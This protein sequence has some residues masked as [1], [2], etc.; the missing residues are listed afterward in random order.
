MNK[1]SLSF[2]SLILL[3]TFARAE[4]YTEWNNNSNLSKTYI[5]GSK[6][7]SINN[8][9]VTISDLQSGKSYTIND[10]NKTIEVMDLNQMKKQMNAL[11]KGVKRVPTGESK[12]VNG[13][14]CDVF[15]LEMEGLGS[16]VDI[17]SCEVHY[18]KLGLSKQSFDRLY[19]ITSKFM[20]QMKSMMDFQSGNMSIE[21]TSSASFGTKPMR[22][23]LKK[24][25]EKELADSFFALPKG[26]KQVEKSMA[27]DSKNI[28]PEEM[29]KAMKK[30]QDMLKNMSP[31]EKAKIEKMINQKKAQ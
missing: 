7:K 23:V 27:G 30:M 6:I 18:S 25:E 8:S 12:T 22:S 1:L 5:K 31:E 13:K 16:F 28:S 21:S 9:V 17:K 3:T 11:I 24:V 26:Y 4:L 20:P 2:F 10:K 19:Q 14:K 29:E 15:K